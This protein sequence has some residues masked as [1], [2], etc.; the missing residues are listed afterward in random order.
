MH[1]LFSNPE[2]YIRISKLVQGLEHSRRLGVATRA[3]PEGMAYCMVI[4]LVI[5]CEDTDRWSRA[6]NILGRA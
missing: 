4:L 3:L 5:C 2:L 6:Y 1:D